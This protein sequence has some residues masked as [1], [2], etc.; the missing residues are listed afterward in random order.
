[1]GSVFYPLSQ[2]IADTAAAH[3]LEWAC[4]YYCFNRRG[5]RLSRFEWKVLATAAAS[6]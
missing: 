3:G 6:L 2:Q 1:M 4:W 5:P